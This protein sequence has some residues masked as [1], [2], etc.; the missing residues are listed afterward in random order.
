MNDFKFKKKFGQNFLVDKNIV[1]KIVSNI[2][3]CDRSLVIEIGCGS[4][5]LTKKLCSCFD[6]VLGYEIDT[7]VKDHLYKNLSSFSNYEI[8]FD[9]F[10]NRDVFSDL[11][12]YDY[13]N[14]YVIANLP[15]YITTP[16][17]ERI[18]NLGLDVKFMRFMVQKEVGD[19]FCA[20]AGSKEYNSLSIY[21]NY[22]Y[23]VK[24]EFVV[25]RNCFFPVPNVDSL[26]VSFYSNADK[27]F[28]RD[29][30][31]FYKL[32]RD[33]FRFKRKTLR[34]NLKGYDL[35][36]VSSV[37]AKHG[38]DLSVRAEQISIE[39]FCEISNSLCI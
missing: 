23:N 38:L 32:V 15:Y 3:I 29:L 28:V 11:K 5:L 4:G 7:E 16:I 27:P 14:L 18:I 24:K 19:R 35:D 17:I 8:V 22:N 31:L 33:S 13:D 6:R 9:D 37:L 36:C 25:N 12:K 39:I 30:D 20:R 1:N 34:N 2:D 21:L 10:L 26:V